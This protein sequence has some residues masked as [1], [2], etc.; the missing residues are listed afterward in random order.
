MRK[1]LLG[2]MVGLFMAGSVP[3]I[4]HAD[5]WPPECAPGGPCAT[6]PIHLP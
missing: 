2:L 3:V 4:A 1:L 5:P 6:L